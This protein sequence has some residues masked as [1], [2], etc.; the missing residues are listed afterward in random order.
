MQLDLAFIGSEPTETN[1]VNSVVSLM[2][3]K[4]M[5]GINVG[6]RSMSTT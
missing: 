2:V 3:T 6:L 1:Y 5:D 4:R